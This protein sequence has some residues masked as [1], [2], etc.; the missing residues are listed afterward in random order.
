MQ[1]RRLLRLQSCCSPFLTGRGELFPNS[2]ECIPNDKEA[3]LHAVN[4]FDGKI[5]HDKH[6]DDVEDGRTLTEISAAI[7]AQLSNEPVYNFC[8]PWMSKHYYS[9]GLNLLW[10]SKQKS[11]IYCN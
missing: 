3:I 8:L 11:T 4:L 1:C 5:H 10:K 7:K 2:D 9:W 6:R